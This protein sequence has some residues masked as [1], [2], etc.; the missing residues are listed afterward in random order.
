M[1]NRGAF[2]IISMALVLSLFGAAAIYSADAQAAPKPLKSLVSVGVCV[3]IILS[4][5]GKGVV[6]CDRIG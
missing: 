6:A 2:R 4:P 5:D 3:G 1:L